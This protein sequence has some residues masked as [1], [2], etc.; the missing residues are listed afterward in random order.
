MQMNKIENKR[1]NNQK[2]PSLELSRPCLSDTGMYI[3]AMYTLPVF[4]LVESLMTWKAVS[5]YNQAFTF[6][7]H[8]KYLKIN[9]LRQ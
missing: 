1:Y 8:G 6:M 2:I 7:Q 3:C 9:I 5:P 4:L